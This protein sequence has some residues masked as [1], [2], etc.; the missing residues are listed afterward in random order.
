MPPNI[1]QQIHNR[2]NEVDKDLAT[3]KVALKELKKFMEAYQI[4]LEERK[5]IQKKRGS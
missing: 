1:T 5:K 3:I 4:V 2:L